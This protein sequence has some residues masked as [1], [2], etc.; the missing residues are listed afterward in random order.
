MVTQRRVWNDTQELPRR[1]REG[2][3][4]ETAP[5]WNGRWHR[6]SPGCPAQTSLSKEPGRPM[7]SSAKGAAGEPRL[8][9]CWRGH[10]SFFPLEQLGLLPGG[11]WPSR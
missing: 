9:S 11:E 8:P 3:E 5:G 7:G 6:K 1:R 2:L 4:V 10:G